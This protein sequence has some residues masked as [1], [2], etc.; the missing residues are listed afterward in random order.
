MFF[1]FH[2]LSDLSV[3]FFPIL[4]T[5]CVS[6]IACITNLPLC[7]HQLSRYPAGHHRQRL[8]PKSSSH[9]TIVPCLIGRTSNR[10]PSPFRCAGKR[11]T[12]RNPKPRVSL[13]I[14]SPSLASA[15]PPTLVA[16]KI[17]PSGKKAEASWTIF[18]RRKSPSK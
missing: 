12:M 10:T 4:V 3:D 18:C 9:V 17:L 5:C 15:M 16:S 1:P 8:S 11:D 2:C 6:G 14:F 7:R 13:G